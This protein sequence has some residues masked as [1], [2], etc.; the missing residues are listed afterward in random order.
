MSDP[1]SDR[2][3]QD[4]RPSNWT[5]RVLAPL[6]L[7]IVAGAVVLLITGT[8]DGSEKKGRDKGGGDQTAATEG[9]QPEAESAVENGYF[10]IE[11]GEDLS[12]VA[13]RTC[14]PIDE[15]I[16]LNPNLDPQLIQVG[17]CVDLVA[18]GCKALAAD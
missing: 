7:L 14:I 11:P 5:A 18:D 16:E 15:L 3:S 8:L 6:A 13:D 10:V 9:C 1:G 17:S 12:V 4:G 2:G